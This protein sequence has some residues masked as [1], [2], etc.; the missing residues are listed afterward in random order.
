MSVIKFFF[1]VKTFLY[2][3]FYW[4]L[5]LPKTFRNLTVTKIRVF[6][7]Y[8]KSFFFVTKIN[9]FKTS[10]SLCFS[11]KRKWLKLFKVQKVKFLEVFTDSRAKR[12]IISENFRQILL[13]FIWMNE[14]SPIS[15][16]RWTSLNDS[17]DYIQVQKLK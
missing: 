9:Y 7:Y 6:L 11:L 12:L 14:F 13:T 8:Q 10:D 1:F 16:E 4:K 15:C 2:L 17:F 5:S 3:C